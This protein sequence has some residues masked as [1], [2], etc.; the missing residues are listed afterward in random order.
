LGVGTDGLSHFVV[1][2]RQHVSVRRH[3][4]RKRG[5]VSNP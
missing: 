5:N 4:K 2:A 3:R 1:H